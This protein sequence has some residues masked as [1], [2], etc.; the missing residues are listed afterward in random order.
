MDP[1]R[2]VWFPDLVY[3]S[4]PLDG[5]VSL[6]NTFANS[7]G[8]IKMMDVFFILQEAMSDDNLCRMYIGWAPFL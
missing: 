7:S 2:E 3:M 5:L 6:N 1:S 8:V 4:C